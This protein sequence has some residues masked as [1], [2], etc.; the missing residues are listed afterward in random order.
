MRFHKTFFWTH[1]I[2]TVSVVKVQINDSV[3]LHFFWHQNFNFVTV[4]KS[5]L[6]KSE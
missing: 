3:I 2:T 6:F 4:G 1:T 5:E